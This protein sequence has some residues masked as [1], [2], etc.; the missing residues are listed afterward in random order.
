MVHILDTPQRIH[1]VTNE[2]EIIPAVAS[3]HKG[4]TAQVLVNAAAGVAKGAGRRML[5]HTISSIY[6]EFASQAL[7][8]NGEHQLDVT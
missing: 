5:W 1:D 3:T 8:G 2:A 7:Q 6:H 4:S